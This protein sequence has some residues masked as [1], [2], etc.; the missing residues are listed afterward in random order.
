M[1]LNRFREFLKQFGHLTPG[2]ADLGVFTDFGDIREGGGVIVEG[3][4]PTLKTVF[5]HTDQRIVAKTDSV[6]AVLIQQF[7]DG[8]NALRKGGV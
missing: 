1:S 4:E 2:F 8:W 3:V 7:G 6:I 5:Q